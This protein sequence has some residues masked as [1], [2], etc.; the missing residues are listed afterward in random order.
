MSQVYTSISG[1]YIDLRY[2]LI[3][4]AERKNNGL[5]L[6]PRDVGDRAITIGAGLNISGGKET[7]RYAVY[8]ALGI[9]IGIA[10]QVN[11]AIGTQQQQDKEALYV[12]KLNAALTGV[13]ASNINERI[14]QLDQIM[15]ERAADNSLN[16]YADNRKQY[17]VFEPGAT[18]E[19]QIRRSFD[20]AVPFYED[21]LRK[22]LGSAIYDLPDFQNS[23][24][25]LVIISSMW[26]GGGVSS[27]LKD[28]LS[29]SKF[30]RAEVWYQFRYGWADNNP[31]F[32][33]GWAKRHYMESTLYG[34][35][36]DSPA[37]PLAEA[38]D[39][40]RMFTLHRD[41]ILRRESNYSGSIALANNEP[42]YKS[43]FSAVGSG[44]VK[45]ISDSLVKAR[46]ILLNDLQ[47]QPN[48]DISHAFD[49]WL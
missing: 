38:K 19:Q 15:T 32:N 42:A 29:P 47:L 9:Q 48:P 39:I 41:E 16:G 2:L 10:G 28:A 43:L 49:A 25:H 44:F 1:N 14:A 36:S 22:R 30:N 27:S 20:E 7:N 11:T 13:T 12:V 5:D 8:R 4:A 18:G 34:L 26:L 46:D 24:E 31:T 33:N 23:K 6:Y 21:D 40:Y 37:D 35:Y 3:A 17:F 45:N